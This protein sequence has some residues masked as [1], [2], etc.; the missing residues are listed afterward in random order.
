MPRGGGKYDVEASALRAVT[1]ADGVIIV[2]LGGNRGSGFSLQ[3]LPEHLGAV[4]TVLEQVV[5]ELRKEE[6]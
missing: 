1:D 2:V 6:S 4:V 5:R 3:I